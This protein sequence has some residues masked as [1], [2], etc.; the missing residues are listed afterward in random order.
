MAD[1]TIT[2]KLKRG[3]GKAVAIG[4]NGD[5]EILPVKERKPRIRRIKRGG[6]R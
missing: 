1:A 2:V 4:V 5:W 6:K 3:R